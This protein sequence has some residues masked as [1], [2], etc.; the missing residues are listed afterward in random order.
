MT[1]LIGLTGAYDFLERMILEPAG[2][3][4][5]PDWKKARENLENS[6][7]EN[8]DYLGTYFPR[9]VL[10]S[11]IIFEHLMRTMPSVK[12]MLAERDVIRVLNFGC[13]T[14]GEL[15]GFLIALGW[16]FNWELPAVEVDAIDGNEDALGMMQDIMHLCR[17][18]W[19][20]DL[21]VRTVTHKAEKSGFAPAN[22]KLRD[23][24]DVLVTSKCL[25]ELN[26]VSQTPFLDFACEFFDSIAPEG[27]I[28]MMDVTSRQPHNRGNDWTNLQMT[29][30]FDTHRLQFRK[31]G[32]RTLFPLVCDG[33]SGCRSHS[34]FLQFI[35][36]FSELGLLEYSE[37]KLACRAYCRDKLW[38]KV[39]AEV[40]PARWQISMGVSCGECREKG[41]GE[42]LAE[43]PGCCVNHKYFARGG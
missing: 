14:G 43:L 3:R 7:D 31:H 15:L 27:L 20:F 38:Q 21:R 1:K 9:T 4:Y 30:E 40:P 29:G 8:L 10:E 33:C 5:N 13:G 39:R 32:F 11:A 25:G 19:D 26:A 18:K 24:Y 42:N 12:K 37:T 28:V 23:D 22:V 36:D 34:R 41:A 35:F 17:D 2:A 6:H 16:E